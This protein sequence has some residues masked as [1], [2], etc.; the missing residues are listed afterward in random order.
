M[1]LAAN[2]APFEKAAPRIL[3]LNCPVDQMQA[4]H[5]G[6]MFGV[7]A[8]KG[9][10]AGDGLPRNECICQA[11]AFLAQITAHLR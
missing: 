11:D 8:D 10:A 5:A 3:A 9:E 7:V 1:A 2:S 4:W 6:E